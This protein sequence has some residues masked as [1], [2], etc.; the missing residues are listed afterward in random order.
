MPVGAG[1]CGGRLSEEAAGRSGREGRS[2]AAAMAEA[3]RWPA[4][5]VVPVGAVAPAGRPA[6]AHPPRLNLR[7]VG[8]PAPAECTGGKAVPDL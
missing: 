4:R 2:A 3:F 6:G 1:R 7:T 8:V 5:T